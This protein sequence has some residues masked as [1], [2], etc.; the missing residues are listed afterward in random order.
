MSFSSSAPFLTNNSGTESNQKY[1]VPENSGQVLVAAFCLSWGVVFLLAGYTDY[2][3][4]FCLEYDATV[5]HATP[6][7]DHDKVLGPNGWIVNWCRQT[8]IILFVGTVLVF[9]VSECL[10]TTEKDRN[11]AY[12]QS[13][14]VAYT[15]TPFFAYMHVFLSCVYILVMLVQSGL[16]LDVT[17]GKSVPLECKQGHMGDNFVWDAVWVF[18]VIS[19]IIMS[20]VAL[21]VIL[22]IF[23]LAIIFPHAA[24]TYLQK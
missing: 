22:M 15:N 20:S 23:G 11:D 14:G 10:A 18:S 24:R 4:N 5:N 19:L 9:F 21:F 6:Y 7:V 1:K 12:M 17:F 13:N 16:I 8:G 2:A 3:D